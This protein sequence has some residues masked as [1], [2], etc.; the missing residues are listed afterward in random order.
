MEKRTM[1]RT[2]V[3][4]L[5]LP[6]AFALVSCSAMQ[7]SFAV[8][9][10]NQLFR[11]EQDA[12]ATYRYLQ[13]KQRAGDWGDWI[14]YDLGTLYVSLGEIDPGIRVL[15]RT[16]ED[17][18]ELPAE[19]GRQDRELFYRSH[20]NLGVA[21]YEIGNYREAAAAFVQALRLKADSWD[22]KVNLELSLQAMAKAAAFPRVQFEKLT[23]PGGEPE[24]PRTEELLESIHG[25]EGPAWVS[26]PAQ[27]RFEQDW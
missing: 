15:N 27:E 14:D 24:D 12:L 6:I 3:A 2:V 13:A 22:A 11:S 26:A 5:L 9:R 18:S 10:G 16:L 17:I 20:F 23:G 7:A 25:E 8:L 4:V 21:Q 1:K 19:P